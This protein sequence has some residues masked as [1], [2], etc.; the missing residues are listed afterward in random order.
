M[1][2]LKCLV[3]SNAKIQ[4]LLLIFKLFSYTHITILKIF[5]S[6]FTTEWWSLGWNSTGISSGEAETRVPCC[7]FCQAAIQITAV[8][9]ALQKAK[10]LFSITDCCTIWYQCLVIKWCRAD[11]C[12]AEK[13]LENGF[14]HDVYILEKGVSKNYYIKA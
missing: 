13:I 6:N 10:L 4:V 2:F 9:I 1:L 14:F 12:H 5:L 8:S 11:I 7:G 3:T